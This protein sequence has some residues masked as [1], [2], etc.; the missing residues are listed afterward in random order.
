[1]Q[2]LPPDWQV[3]ICGYRTVAFPCDLLIEHRAYYE[4]SPSSKC[5][6]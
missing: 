5:S 4:L 6:S 1:M 2:A 3:V